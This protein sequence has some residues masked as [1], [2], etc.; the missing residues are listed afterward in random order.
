LLF[1]RIRELV[2][3]FPWILRFHNYLIYSLA[4]R[5][6]AACSVLGGFCK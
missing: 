1:G 3:N 5:C 4:A 6:V 2:V